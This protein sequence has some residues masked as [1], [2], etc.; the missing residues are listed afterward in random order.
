MLWA[1]VKVAWLATLMDDHY[2]SFDEDGGWM[3]VWHYRHGD[4]M[5]CAKQNYICRA[6]HFTD[7]KLRRATFRINKRTMSF[8]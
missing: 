8:L 6:F 4:G 1:M 2:S 7:Q 5:E 3:L